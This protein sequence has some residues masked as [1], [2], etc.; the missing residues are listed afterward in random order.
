MERLTEICTCDDN[1]DSP[2][3]R[4]KIE[5]EQQNE[6][7]RL[8]NHLKCMR[9]LVNKQA[10]DEGLWFIAETAPEAY[11]QKELRKLHVAIEGKTQEDCVRDLA[12]KPDPERCDSCMYFA[13]RTKHPRKGHEVRYG[14]CKRYP[15]S[16][17]AKDKYRW[18][19]AGYAFPE[20]SGD[21]WC[22]EYKCACPKEREPAVSAPFCHV[23]NEPREGDTCPHCNEGRL[24]L[25]TADEPY[26]PVQLQCDKCDSTYPYNREQ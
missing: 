23:V 5:N 20:M 6:I 8:R 1:C 19:P 21:N 22:G 26:H 16:A 25:V 12:K 2:C 3:P 7:I 18:I 9:S 11:L 14:P 15:P 24:D 17:L 4:H 13:A 10:E